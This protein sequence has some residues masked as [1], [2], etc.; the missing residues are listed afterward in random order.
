MTAPGSKHWC[1]VMRVVARLWLVSL[2]PQLHAG[3]QILGLP[4]ESAPVGQFVVLHFSYVNVMQYA[5]RH[6]GVFVG[7]PVVPPVLERLAYVRRV[8]R[9]KLSEIPRCLLHEALPN[10]HRH[11]AGQRTAGKCCHKAAFETNDSDTSTH[12]VHCLLDRI[13]LH[14]HC[15]PCPR[16]SVLEIRVLSQVTFLQAHCASVYT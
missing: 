16:W 11:L 14:K 15:H 3:L 13:R 8:V 4:G 2:S 1:R 9:P 10:D 7:V 6:A 12:T 5:P